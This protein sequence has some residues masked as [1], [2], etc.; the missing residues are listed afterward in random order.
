MMKWI[1]VLVLGNLLIA[2]EAHAT[3]SSEKTNQATEYLRQYRKDWSLS[4]TVAFLSGDGTNKTTGAVNMGGSANEG[5]TTTVT[6]HADDGRSVS[7]LA[8][9][10]SLLVDGKDVTGTLGNKTTYGSNSP[11]I[12]DVK[13]SQIAA[14]EKNKAGRD[15]TTNYSLTISLSL[16][17]SLSVI[18]NLYQ[19]RKAKGKAGP[20]S[21]S[22]E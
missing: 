21:G 7:L 17:L 4:D 5:G 1:I 2:H 16:A 8:T 6:L 13:D 15:S 19:L 14:G 20:K 3:W 11:I 22:T 10:Q 9:G 12:E 18:L